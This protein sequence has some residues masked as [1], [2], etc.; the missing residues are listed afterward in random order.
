MLSDDF[1]RICAEAKWVKE[2]KSSWAS[3]PFPPSFV[4]VDNVVV[5]SGHLFDDP[6]RRSSR[7]RA[8]GRCPAGLLITMKPCLK[9][10][11]GSSK[12]RPGWQT[13]MGRSRWVKLKGFLSGQGVFD[14]PKRSV[15]GYTLT[16]AFLFKLPP[17]KELMSVIGSDDAVEAKWIPIAD[18]D[19]RDCFEDHY[20]IIN[21][22]LDGVH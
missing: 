17:A 15:R 20:F 5:Q 4:T 18:L 16:H 13:G 11:S 14:D 9:A 19:P 3:A 1:K 10:Q 2:Y 12:K 7:Q 21:K 6:A 8:F 22:M